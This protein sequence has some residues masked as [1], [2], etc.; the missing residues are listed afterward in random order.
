ITR[1]GGPPVNAALKDWP[2]LG[3]YQEMHRFI[4]TF[5]IREVLITDPDINAELLFDT[6]VKCGRGAR[7]AFRVVPNLLNCIPRKTNVEQLGSLPMVRL[8]EEP[9]S[10]YARLLK[11]SVDIAVSSLILLLSAPL[12]IIIAIAIKLE[13]KGSI[14]Y[15]QERV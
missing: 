12:W 3:S 11:R 1:D 2:V 4:R 6:M 10:A 5:G 9:L 7:V 13:S 8:F 15:R 14:F